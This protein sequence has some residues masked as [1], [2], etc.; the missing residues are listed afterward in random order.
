MRNFSV[1]DLP[2]LIPA[3]P[4]T[5]AERPSTHRPTC[6]FS[7][8]YL[9][10]RTRLPG[11]PSIVPKPQLGTLILILRPFALL[12]TRP[13]CYR[14]CGCLPL[15]IVGRVDNYHCWAPG[16][17]EEGWAQLKTA[18]GSCLT[19]SDNKSPLCSCRE[20]PAKPAPEPVL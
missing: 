8:P 13:V 6:L 3:P 5:G 2:C 12:S 17:K 18:H 19:S 10:E 4:S 14:G 20:A 16:Y 1:Q 7:C 11:F 9:W 15:F